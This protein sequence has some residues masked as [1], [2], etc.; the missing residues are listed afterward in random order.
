MPNQESRE[1]DLVLPPNTHAFILNQQKGDIDCYVGPHKSNLDAT[2]D[3]PV[4]FD[5]QT[6]RFK[7]VNLLESSKQHLK[8]QG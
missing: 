5:Y 7:K 2:S 6:K 4:I 3:Q 1:R 8:Y